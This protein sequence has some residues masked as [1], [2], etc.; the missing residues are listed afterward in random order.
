[1]Y[2]NIRWLCGK[3]D[4]EEKPFLANVYFWRA[5][6]NPKHIYTIPA[7][8]SFTLLEIFPSYP[9]LKTNMNNHF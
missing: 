7:F 8:E 2:V 4:K 9:L 6:K 3:W 5:K 1:M